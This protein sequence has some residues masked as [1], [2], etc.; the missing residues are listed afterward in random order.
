MI[1]EET[2]EALGAVAVVRAG[3]EYRL[4]ADRPVGA[5]ELLFTIV[6]EETGTPTRYTVQVGHGVHI[7]VPAEF[8]LEAVLDRFYW[9][10]MNHG[11]DPTVVVR[12][13]GVVSLKP[14]EFGQEITFNY[15]TTEYDMVEPFSCR[16]GSARCAGL[17]RGFR[18]LPPGER[19]GLRPWLAGH[20]R[21][22]ES[23]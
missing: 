5:G 6:G 7:D 2:V 10:F 8:A 12:G 1:V 13:R 20:L 16:C 11:C 18:Y 17:V 19:E 4:V 14:I 23:R 22:V 21:S 15:N 9:R 3:G